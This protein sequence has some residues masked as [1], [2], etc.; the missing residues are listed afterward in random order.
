MKTD[1][2]KALQLV[3]KSELEPGLL[4]SAQCY[5]YHIKN[6][7]SYFLSSEGQCVDAKKEGVS[8]PKETP[9]KHDFCGMSGTVPGA[10]LEQ[11]D[12]EERL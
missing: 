4:S 1:F 10:S 8:Q 12:G 11:G 3:T 7:K 2:S 9:L 6:P 5:F